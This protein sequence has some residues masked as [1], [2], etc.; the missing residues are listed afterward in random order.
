M[1]GLFC[2]ALER[3]LSSILPWDIPWY[4]PSHKVFFLA[5]YG[6]LGFIGLGVVIAVLMTM[7]KLKRGESDSHH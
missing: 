5:L 1:G 3:S 6:A 4:D 7:W 2:R